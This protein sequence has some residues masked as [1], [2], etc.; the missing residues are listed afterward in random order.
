MRIEVKGLDATLKKFDRLANKSKDD[1]QSAL[2]A[3]AADVAT[4]A[5]KF[6]PGNEGKLKQSISPVYGNLEGGVVASVNYAAFIE[7]GTRKF[8]AEY[9]STLPTDWQNIANSKKGGNGGSIKGLLLALKTWFDQRGIPKDKQF[10]I[11]RKIL[12]DG[13]K[14]QPFIYP[15]INKNKEQLI[16]DIKAIFK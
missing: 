16:K 7:F 3:F 9:V 12:R 2:N 4:D 10:F 11:A 14:S 6:A 8:A 1:I 5:V 15:A 13:V